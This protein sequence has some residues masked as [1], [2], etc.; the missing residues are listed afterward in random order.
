LPEKWIEID[1]R[2][3]SAGAE[4]SVTDSGLGIPKEIQSKIHEPFFTTKANGKGA[5]L[6]LSISQ[7]IVNAH[8]GTLTLDV[9]SRNTRF[10]ITLPKLTQLPVISAQ[11][12]S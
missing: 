8:R 3:T 1:V 9:N 7:R 5:G 2:D 11:K 6:G 12:A 10:V 4:I